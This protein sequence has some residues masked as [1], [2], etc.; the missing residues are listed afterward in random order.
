LVDEGVIAEF[1]SQ[2]YFLMKV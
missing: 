1:I 2:A